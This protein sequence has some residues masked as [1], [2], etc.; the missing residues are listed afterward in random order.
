M[1]R[2]NFSTLSYISII[3]LIISISFVSTLNVAQKIDLSYKNPEKCSETVFCK[4]GFKCVESKCVIIEKNPETC[5]SNDVC[6]ANNFC[7]TQ[8]VNNVTTSKCV[9]LTTKEQ[10]AE[11]TINSV[12]CV[13]SSKCVKLLTVNDCV[14][15]YVLNP[16][17]CTCTTS[18][19]NNLMYFGTIIGMIILMIGVLIFIFIF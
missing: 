9:E 7:S 10:C 18:G 14:G 6:I 2:L 1:T 16:A 15:Q 8:T 12:W 19:W 5:T 11:Q 13:Q 17:T 3:A 4:H